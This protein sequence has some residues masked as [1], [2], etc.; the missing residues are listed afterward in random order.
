MSNSDLSPRDLARYLRLCRKTGKLFWRPRGS[1]NWDNRYAGKQALT[2]YKN[3]YRVGAINGK[4]VR[5]H[6]A[7]WAL[8][9][10]YWPKQIDHIN[11]D[12]S[13]NRPSN[14]RDVSAHENLKNKRLDHRN[15]SGVSGVRMIRGKFWRV[16]VGREYI[17]QTKC[18]LNAVKTRREAEAA[19][20]YH[21]NHGRK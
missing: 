18:F 8:M 4:S 12:R 21:E 1:P 5:A 11:G 19:R 7:V 13:D 6:R 9:H 3:G 2:S 15:R 16:T 20:G 14:L 17:K 10:G